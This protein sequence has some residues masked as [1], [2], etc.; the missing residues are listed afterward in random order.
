M[1]VVAPVSGQIPIP[2]PNIPI[3]QTG[4]TIMVPAFREEP[5]ISPLGALWRSMLVPGWGQAVLGRRV[6]GTA[7]VF[8]EGVTVTMT[9]KAMHQRN[10]M[11]RTGSNNVEDKK[12][13]IQDWAVLWGFNHLLAG[14]EAF[15]AALLWDFPVELETGLSPTGEVLV[16]VK[17]NFK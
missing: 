2:I 17:Y 15:V 12:Q 16:G 10:Y 9:L 5:P 7:F 11:E 6:T 14:A 13:E 3:P 8:W 1:G 4:D